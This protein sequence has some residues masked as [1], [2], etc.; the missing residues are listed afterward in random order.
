MVG[1]EIA[2]LTKAIAQKNAQQ[3]AREKA[4]QAEIDATKAA[5]KKA[6]DNLEVEKFSYNIADQCLKNRPS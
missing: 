3:A 2:E 1:K 5:F 6:A 4:E